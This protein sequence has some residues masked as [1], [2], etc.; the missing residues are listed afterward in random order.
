MRTHFCNNEVVYERLC[1][2]SIVEQWLI[3]VP[4][5]KAKVHGKSDSSTFAL[6]N[7][8]HTDGCAFTMF[9]QIHEKTASERMHVGFRIMH[10]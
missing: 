8:L 1:D 9:G 6:I 4:F 7:E 10:F 3:T 2:R 5:Q